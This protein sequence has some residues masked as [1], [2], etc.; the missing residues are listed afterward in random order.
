MRQHSL[1]SSGDITFNEDEKQKMSVEVCFVFFS[2][3]IHWKECTDLIMDALDK[4]QKDVILSFSGKVG[5]ML[6]PLFPSF[7]E[8]FANRKA[9]GVVTS[10]L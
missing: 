2:F 7:V 1:R 4:K 6:K 5:V 3:F 8:Y 10:K 9:G